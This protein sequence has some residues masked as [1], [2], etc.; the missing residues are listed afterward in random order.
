MIDANELMSKAKGRWYGILTNF[1]IPES[2]LT[3]K[4]VPFLQA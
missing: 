4:H 3:G 2:C 1:G